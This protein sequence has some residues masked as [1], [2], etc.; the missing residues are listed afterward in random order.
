MKKVCKIRIYPNNSQIK[1]INETLGCCRYVK[2][3][4]IEYNQ[5][6]YNEEGRF[7]S[8]YDFSK[9]INKLKKTSNTYSW[10]YKYS[11]KAIKDAIMN[12]EKAFKRFFKQSGGF[13]KFKSRKSINK[14]SFF[15]IKDSI[16]Y[17]VNPRIIKLPILGKIRITEYSYLPDIDTITSGRIIRE[18]DKYYVS[19]IYEYYPYKEKL[20]E[21]KI[22]IDVGLISYA[23]IASSNGDVVKINHFKN[24]RKYKD[25]DKKITKLQQIL[26]NKAEINYAKL[27]HKWMDK[28]SGEDLNKITKN[29]MKGESYNSSQ[30]RRLRRKIRV[31]KQKQLNIRRNFVNKLVYFLTARTKPTE[32][33]IEDLG[34]KEMIKHTNEHDTSLHKY[35]S[36]SLFYYFREKMIQ[37]CTEFFIK[38][39]IA[40]R[41]FASSKTCSNCGKKNKLLKLSD[42][43]FK[44]DECGFVIDR[45]EN[46]SINLLNL[47]DK[48]CLI[49]NIA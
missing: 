6:I 13:P 10:I 3:L 11:S 49:I 5:K 26:S 8:G 21:I 37:K 12:E 31:L 29:I 18:Y 43:T 38:L 39:R 34:I 9:I 15:F 16:R 35:I 2:N 32:I 22:G 19:F 33:T 40:E 36:E 27:L 4:Y 46:A 23:T 24:D 30:I 48:K 25:I 20:N 42:R 7:I 1:L 28:H 47:K 45:D 14:E 44:C 41:Y 17:T